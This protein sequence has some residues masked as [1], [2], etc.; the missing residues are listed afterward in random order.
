MFRFRVKVYSIGSWDIWSMGE[1]AFCT[2]SCLATKSNS[3]KSIA[4]HSIYVRL[5]TRLIQF[6]ALQ[7]ICSPA[8]P[9]VFEVTGIVNEWCVLYAYMCTNN[10]KNTN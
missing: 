9:H 1:Y 5:S 7:G 4:L 2:L 6:N 8:G 10:N 3:Y